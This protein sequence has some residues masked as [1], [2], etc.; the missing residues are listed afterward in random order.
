M[1]RFY[2]ATDAAD[3][4][5]SLAFF[6]P[7]A[8]ITTWAEGVNGRHWQEQTYSGAEQIRQVL[9][10]K[11]FRRA[12]VA[13]DGPAFQI[14]DLKVSA[15][16]VSFWLRPDRLSPDKKQYDPY[17]VVATFRDCLISRMTVMEFLAWE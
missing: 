7:D 13:P 3:L 9:S 1:N 16:E 5:K 2:A 6:S 8:A 4:D 17:R 14:A 12:A 11:G 10:H 15:T